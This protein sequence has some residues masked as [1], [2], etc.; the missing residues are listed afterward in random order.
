MLRPRRVRR[1]PPSLPRRV[2]R[3][4][5]NLSLASKQDGSLESSGIQQVHRRHFDDLDE[6]LGSLHCRRSEFE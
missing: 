2:S 6:Y 3:R 1:R 5:L 4:T